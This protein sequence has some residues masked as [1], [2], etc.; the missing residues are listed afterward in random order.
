MKEAIFIKIQDKIQL[1]VRGLDPPFQEYLKIGELLILTLVVITE[2]G[3]HLKA[4]QVNS[5]HPS[6]KN[7]Y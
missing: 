5:C 7:S 2:E 4:L 6:N 1:I 3:K